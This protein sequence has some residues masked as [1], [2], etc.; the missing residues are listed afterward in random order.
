MERVDPSAP[1]TTSGGAYHWQEYGIDDILPREAG[2]TVLLLGCG[3]ASERPYLRERGY[4]TVGLDVKPSGRPDLLADAHALP[5][6]PGSFDGVLSMQVLEHLHS[7]WIAVEEI[8]RILKSGGWFVGSVA[9]LKPY[10]GSFFHMTHDGV[11]TLLRDAGL[12]TDH[13]H[14]AQSLTYTMYDWLLPIPSRSWRRRLLGA[15][16]GVLWWL[17]SLVWWLTRQV[18]PDRPTDRFDGELKFSFR[19]FD[20][21]RFAPAIVFRARKGNGRDY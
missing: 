15:V 2:G 16:D 13:I 4:R 8:S 20:K 14:G 21:L 9:F 12:E 3:D 7:P 18:D 1:D 11:L 5:F 17:R 6:G 10:H 19:A